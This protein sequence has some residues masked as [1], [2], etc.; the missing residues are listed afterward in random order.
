M[1]IQALLADH[2]RA[3]RAVALTE[4]NVAAGVAYVILIGA[5][6]LTAAIGLGW[7]AALLVSL[8]CPRSRGCVNRRLTIEA[9]PA[10][11]SARAA[12]RHVLGRGRDAVLHDRRRVVHHGVG[13]VLRRGRGGRLR[14]HGR[15]ADVRLLR[16]RAHRARARQPARA[17]ATRRRLL[18]VALA[19][20]AAGFAVLW[21]SATR[22]RRVAGLAII[23]VGLGNLFPL[24]LA[25]C[26]AL[27]AGS[28]AVG[29]QPRRCWPA[30]S[31]VLLAPLTIGALA[32]AT[33]ITAALPVVPVM[34]VLAA[35]G[36]TLVRV[37]R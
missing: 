22:C 3:F 25:V 15:R 32:D 27:A 7:R 35:T 2:H 23:G 12:P 34:L 37:T 29:V 9:P 1:T 4:A 11:R 6:S 36:L 16:R 31:A 24:G 33:S 20:T 18:A 8:R 30:S 19:V 21:P 17:D 10:E 26:V 28:R 13:R 14:R 5:L